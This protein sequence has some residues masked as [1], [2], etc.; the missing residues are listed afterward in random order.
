MTVAA[1]TFKIS[2]MYNYDTVTQ[3]IEGLKKRGYDIDFNLD[4]ENDSIRCTTLPV[5]LKP[6]EFEITEFYRFE[7]NS[8]PGDE[9]IVYG[10][11]SRKGQKGIL[12]NGFGV[13]AD[14]MS[15]DMIKKL[16]VAH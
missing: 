6:S 1:F 8:D 11:E 14:T 16:S 13:S 2:A 4:S 7:G 3:A 12:V 5:S 15:N 9:A 10:I